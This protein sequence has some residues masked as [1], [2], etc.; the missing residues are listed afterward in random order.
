MKP[1]IEVY[2]K[3]FNRSEKVFWSK[4]VSTVFADLWFVLGAKKM[5]SIHSGI[6]IFHLI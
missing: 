4:L 2:E 5:A 1:L 3:D 6:K